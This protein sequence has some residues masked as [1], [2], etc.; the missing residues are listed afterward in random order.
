MFTT[1]VVPS[2]RGTRQLVRM[3]SQSGRSNRI[4]GVLAPTSGIVHVAIR[5]AKPGDGGW[6]SG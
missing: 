5:L 3:K 1:I 6:P 2:D 4:T